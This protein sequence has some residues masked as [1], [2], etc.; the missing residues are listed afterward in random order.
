MIVNRLHPR[1]GS[2]SAAEAAAAADAARGVAAHRL[3]TNLAEL[4][5]MAERE[6]ESVSPLLDVAGE[7]AVARVPLLARDVHDLDGL[8]R[9]ATHLV[10][11][12]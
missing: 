12:S 9:L 7:A 3:W 1:F 8:R 4:R 10:A 6:E 2:G 5:R 11:G